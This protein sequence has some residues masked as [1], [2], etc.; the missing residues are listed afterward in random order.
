MK[1]QAILFKRDLFT[2]TQARK[3]LKKMKIKPLKRVHI[4]KQYLRYRLLD[5]KK[6]K[7]KTFRT[8]R[9]YMNGVKA[10]VGELL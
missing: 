6:F 1:K 10:I 5:P 4:T 2:T 7:K 8:H 9:L 3:I